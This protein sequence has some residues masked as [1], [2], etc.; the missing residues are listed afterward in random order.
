M[1]YQ[2]PFRTLT[3]PMLKSYLHF[4]A[5]FLCWHTD[6]TS[7][8]IKLFTPYTLHKN[9]RSI[10]QPNALT[11]YGAFHNVLRDYKHL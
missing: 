5:V 11:I 8:V 7:S 9:F 4:I 1:I 3:E 10:Y 2:H 6:V